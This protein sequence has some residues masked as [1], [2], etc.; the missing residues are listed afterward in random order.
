MLGGS[1]DNSRPEWGPLFPAPQFDSFQKR[2]TDVYQSLFKD[3][4]A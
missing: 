1:G 3:L 2:R 4:M